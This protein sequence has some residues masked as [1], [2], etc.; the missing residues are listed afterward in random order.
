METH[1]LGSEG[2]PGKRTNG[3]TGTAP[4]A[5]LTS[6]LYHHAL[7]HYARAVE[8]ATEAGDPYCQATALGYAG[9]ATAEHGHPNDGLKMTQAAQ[10]AAWDIP[11]DD[12]WAVVVGESGK[13]AV[14]ATLLADSA[15][16]L[17][18][19][20]EH[21]EAGR[22][23]ARGRDLWTPTPADPFGD[24]DRNAARLEL[25][26]GRLDVAETLVVTSLRRWEGGRQISRTQTGVVL[27]TIH[28]TAGEPR[29]LTLAHN[30]I[31][32]VARLGSVRVRSQLTPLAEALEA[33]LSS[34]AKDL[35]RTAR[36]IAA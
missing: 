17:A 21:A 2:G 4:G 6:G 10:V 22:A 8:L 1:T 28:V 36:Q 31:T 26:R 11:P 16:A 14:E 9:M 18:L 19:L 23:V 35:A 5:Y 30:V 33:R 25:G 20:G 12:Q 32:G 34:D 27:A 3:N 13:A 24:P 15:T 29:G 7:Y